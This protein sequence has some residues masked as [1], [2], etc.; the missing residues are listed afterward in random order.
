MVNASGK[1]QLWCGSGL[2][3]IAILLVVAGCGVNARAQPI[4]TVPA[5]PTPDKTMDAIVRGLVTVVLPTP[6]PSRVLATTAR[7]APTTT[8]PALAT[9]RPATVQPSPAV[10]P[11]RAP[12]DAPT[13]QPPTAVPVT[14][15]AIAPTAAPAVQPT[16]GPATTQPTP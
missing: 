12:T 3:G 10:V 9:P 2:W 16:A 7:A 1:D 11:S 15:V 4:P 6:T 8:S 13:R 14:P 5:Q